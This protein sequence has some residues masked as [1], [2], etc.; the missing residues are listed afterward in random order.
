MEFKQVNGKWERRERKDSNVFV[1]LTK[2]GNV[3][4]LP[5]FIET[6]K[7]RYDELI[8]RNNGWS[9]I[10]VPD[11][12]FYDELG[13]FPIFYIHNFHQNLIESYYCNVFNGR[14]HFYDR[15]EKLITKCE[16]INRHLNRRDR[17]MTERRLE[18]KQILLDMD[19]LLKD[20]T[21]IVCDYL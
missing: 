8:K 7:I 17:K 20:L 1:I 5:N 15:F 12:I 4:E 16:Q 13:I 10:A 21:C 19:V 9:S 6:K 11:Q 2:G 14:W 18:T 3:V